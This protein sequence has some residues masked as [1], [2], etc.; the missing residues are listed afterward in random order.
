MN[1]KQK[2]LW[3]NVQK[4]YVYTILTSLGFTHGVWMIF[5][6]TRGLSL[7]ELG[8]LES[9][10]HVTS[11]LMEVPTG[12]IADLYGRK[13]SRIC[14]RVVSV[15]SLIVMLFAHS[16]PVAVVSFVLSAL[17]Y[18]LESGAGTALIY[19]SMKQCGKEQEFMKVSGRVEFLYQFTS[20]FA[21]LIGGYLATLKHEWAFFAEIALGLV[22]LVQSSR[23]KEPDVGRRDRSEWKHAGHAMATQL[24]ESFQAFRNNPQIG[25][26]MLSASGLSAF[27]TAQFYYI[28]NFLKQAGSSEFQVGLVLAAAS[29]VSAFAGAQTYRLRKWQPSTII[30]LLPIILVAGFLLIGFT[31]FEGAGFVLV[32][33][34]EG[35]LYVVS[36]DLLNKRIASEQ[37]AT[38]L[39]FDNMAHSLVMIGLFPLIGWMGDVWGLKAAFAVSAL[40]SVLAAGMV[41]RKASLLK[42]VPAELE[43][44]VSNS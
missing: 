7:I 21:F 17:S 15:L 30:C 37:R 34:I 24:T 18:N 42:A 43:V 2:Q 23:F 40:M 31:P 32:S 39:S 26:I 4:Q 8:L 3:K 13:T 44:K 6:A 35:V 10:F 16:F 36:Q 27:V 20:V 5:L 9:I 28:Q 25:Y 29:I 14:G 1:T 11:F 12:A 19:D 22:V 41:I 33:A 38:L